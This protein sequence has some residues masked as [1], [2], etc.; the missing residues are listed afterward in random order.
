M[1]S[2]NPT[3]LTKATPSTLTSSRHSSSQ[4]SSFSVTWVNSGPFP[5]EVYCPSIVP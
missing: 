3:F 4:G 2:I 1:V 5:F